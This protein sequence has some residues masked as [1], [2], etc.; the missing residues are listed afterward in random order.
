MKLSNWFIRPSVI[1]RDIENGFIGAGQLIGKVGVA[2]AQNTQEFAA[3]FK[4]GYK[5]E[6]NAR[7]LADAAM[8]SVEL[9]MARNVE[10]M[11]DLEEINRRTAQLIA[12]RMSRKMA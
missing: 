12:A 10:E 1:V 8:V 2:T 11:H 3:G 9:S 7:K 5:I 6:R 4:R